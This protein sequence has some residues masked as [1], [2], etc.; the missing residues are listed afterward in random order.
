MANKRYQEVDLLETLK[1]RAAE[2]TQKE[3]ATELGVSPQYMNDLIKGRRPLDL[4]TKNGGTPEIAKRLGYTLVHY[5]TKDA[6]ER[7]EFPAPPPI[8]KGK[9]FTYDQFL[10]ILRHMIGD[11]TYTQV[12]AEL[13][14]GRTYFSR[15]MT[16][17]IPVTAE[18]AKAFGYTR[19]KVRAKEYYFVKD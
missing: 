9:R 4:P 6:P 18:L 14:F 7:Y 5:Y 17:E 1:K 10:S 15:V 19:V 12:S 3:L 16:K 13:G 11:M 8:K 2:T